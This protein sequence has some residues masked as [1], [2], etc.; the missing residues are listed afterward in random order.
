MTQAKMKARAYSLHHRA[1]GE[2]GQLRM[3]RMSACVVEIVTGNHQVTW[4]K[5][6]PVRSQNSTSCDIISSC[7]CIYLKV[8]ISAHGSSALLLCCLCDKW[9]CITHA[10]IQRL[11]TGRTLMSWKE[12]GLWNWITL[13]C[14]PGCP[15]QHLGPYMRWFSLSEP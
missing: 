10:F 8:E 4:N 12:N 1:Y 6:C 7:N 2:R 9:H 5:S 11:P 15:R 14:N 13:G 3:Y